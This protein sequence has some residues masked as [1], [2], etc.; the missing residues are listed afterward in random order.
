MRE[1]ISQRHEE[2]T[3]SQYDSSVRRFLDF[4]KLYMIEG[5]YLPLNPE[6]IQLWF[7]FL[8]MEKPNNQ[9]TTYKT[10]LAALRKWSRDNG[11]RDLSCL[12]TDLRKSNQSMFANFIEGFK[13][14]IPVNMPKQAKA[15]DKDLLTALLAYIESVE[16]VE[17]VR[18]RDILVLSI[19]FIGAL[20]GCDLALIN[21]DQIVFSVE[22]VE[23]NFGIHL[24]GGKM[25]K[26]VI[27]KITVHGDGHSIDIYRKMKDYHAFISQ[28]YKDCVLTSDKRGSKLFP[29]INQKSMTVVDNRIDH[30]VVTKIIRQR[31]GEYFKSV[32][33][34]LTDAQLDEIVA[35]YSSHSMKRGLATHAIDTGASDVQVTKAGRWTNVTTMGKYVDS[36]VMKNALE[37]RIK[38]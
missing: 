35:P 31:I 22:Q 18:N 23:R 25:N 12:E 3:Q 2:S 36:S 32:H 24:F 8:Q 10:H 17:L 16:E 27:G 21:I 20:R 26:K 13:K 28:L 34:E 5:P 11:F 14:R 30:K 4:L 1:I 29:N 33:D 6:N 19:M 7:T 9:Y 37:N 15:L 38:L